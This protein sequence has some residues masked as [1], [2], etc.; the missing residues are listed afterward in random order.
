MSLTLLAKFSGS[1]VGAL[2]LDASISEAHLKEVKVTDHPLERGGVVSDHVQRQPET[3]T[4]TGVV[5]NTP[6]PTSKN[7]VRT[8][9]GTVA[10]VPE[11]PFGAA[12][13][14]EAAFTTLRRYMDTGEVLSVVT[15][16]HTYESMVLTSLSVGLDGGAGEVLPFMA[17]LR[18]VRFVESQR[19][20]LAL[21]APKEKAKKKNLG[22]K[23]PEVAKP[24]E[25]DKSALQE[26]WDALTSKTKDASQKTKAGIGGLPK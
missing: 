13:R 4:I 26:M 18:E 24:A 8:E 6:I 3:I 12:S 2:Q 14:A 11:A 5:S 20:A 17:T 23:K 1:K 9:L 16:L 25:V 15:R 19:V 10:D 21:V 7:T 22:P